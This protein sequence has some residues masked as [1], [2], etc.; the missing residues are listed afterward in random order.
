MHRAGL[1]TLINSNENTENVNSDFLERN[2][3]VVYDF[4]LFY[5]PFNVLLTEHLSERQT[6]VLCR[7]IITLHPSEGSIDHTL[8]LCTIGEN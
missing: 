5:K 3:Q 1:K 2:K 7:R 8:H 6:I 4:F